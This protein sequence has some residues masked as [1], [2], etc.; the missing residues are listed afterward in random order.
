MLAVLAIAAT[1]LACKR[2]RS[3]AQQLTP[4]FSGLPTTLRPQVYKQ[5]TGDMSYQHAYYHRI[6]HS[7]FCRA[8]TC[9]YH[10]AGVKISARSFAEIE[11]EFWTADRCSGVLAEDTL[12]V[13]K[14]VFRALD[15]ALASAVLAK[16]TFMHSP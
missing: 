15:C 12:R 6:P 13:V 9:A 16:H 1:S 5:V 10:G 8:F 4:S 2:R 3:R 7:D 14:V 11:L